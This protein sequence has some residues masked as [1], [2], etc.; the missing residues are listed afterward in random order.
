MR[1]RGRWSCPVVGGD[2][3]LS[4]VKVADLLLEFFVF[5]PPFFFLRNLN[6]VTSTTRRLKEIEKGRGTLKRLKSDA[7]SRLLVVCANPS[8]SPC[9]VLFGLEGI[10]KSPACC[11]CSLLVSQYKKTKP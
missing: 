6:L 4:L 5:L 9:T 3:G 10:H 11:R 8:N 2:A 7:L 1:G